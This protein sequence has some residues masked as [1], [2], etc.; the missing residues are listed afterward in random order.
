MKKIALVVFVLFSGSFLFA[1]TNGRVSGTVKDKNTQEELSGVVLRFVGEDIV[2]TVSGENGSFAIQLPVGN[3]NLE[4][5]SIGYLPYTSYNIYVSTGNVQVLQVEMDENIQRL[6]EV[7]IRSGKSVRAT[8]MVTPLATQRLTSEEIKANPGGNFDVSK[9]IQ[10]LPGVAGGTTPNRNDIIVRGGGPSE[11]VYYLDGIEIP[12]LNHFQTQGASGGATGILNVS[13]IQ[14]VQLTS[15]AFD[16]RYNNA[17]ASTIE[18][19][20]RNGNPDKLSGNVRLSGTEFATMLEGPLGK[21]TTFMASARRSYLQFLFQLLDL[22]IR[23]DYYDFQYKV[24]HKIDSKTEVN[25]IG[26]GAI[27]NFEL[28]IPKESD[29]NTAYINRANPLIKQWNYTMGASLKK[30]VENGYF[31]LALSRNTFFNGADRYENNALKTGEKLFA[32]ESHEI[33]NK[34]RFD[35]NKYTDGWKYSYGMDAQYAKYDADIFN[36]V[37]PTVSFSSNTA[38]DFFKFGIYGHV[39]N[40]F[41]DEKFLIS[42][43]VRADIN[44]FTKNGLNPLQTISPRVSFSYAF[45]DKWNVSASVGSYYKL[46]VYTMLG[47]KDATDNL[48]NKNLKYTNAIHYTFGTQFIPR[49]DLRFTLEAFYKDY[50]NYPVSFVNGISYANI[51]TDFSAVGSDN[52]ISFGKG[53]VYGVE[54]YL[55]QKLIK[56]LFYVASA[57]I[58]KSEFAGI[59][60][61]YISSTWD[62]GFIVSSTLGYKFR[63]NWDIG[64]KYRIAGGQPYTPFDMQESTQTYLSNGTGTLDYSQ[65]NSKKLPVFNQ[66]DVRVDKKFNFKTVSLD[67]F[68]DFQNILFYKTPSLPKFTFERTDDNSDFKTTDGLP[69]KTDGSNA[70]PL[71]LE[72][73]SANIVPSIGF[74]F[75]F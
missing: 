67:L 49:N 23:P 2:N 15:S 10:V 60:Q 44:T 27:D 47:Y 11:N 28:A 71:I 42:G 56:N 8:D 68:V 53:R 52:Y 20:Q 32:L 58:F 13:F 57:T 66:L 31:T 14:D 6:Q 22:P 55:Q 72:Q 74:V 40:Y 41:F 48:V 63:K 36:T 54:A 17:L 29:A 59:D 5:T 75:E 9:V 62:Y 38:I 33:E 61:Q 73:R 50:N 70:M 12:V 37:S 43:G 26:I 7:V 69:I 35:M 21:K 18:I 3:Y 1:Q 46:P 65:L 64:I 34:L 24:N 30:L 4:A 45:D 19:K 39:S 25:F 16:S 51:G